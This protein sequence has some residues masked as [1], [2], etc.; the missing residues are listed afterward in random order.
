[1]SAP[2]LV[3]YGQ[4]AHFDLPITLPAGRRT[5]P[6]LCLKLIA[7]SGRLR[8]VTP[9]VGATLAVADVVLREVG[10]WEYQWEADIVLEHGKVFVRATGFVR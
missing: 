2:R 1:M 4:S 6:E 10:Y 7:P 8:V 3:M 9:Q 5:M